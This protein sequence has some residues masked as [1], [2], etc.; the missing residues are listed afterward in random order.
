MMRRGSFPGS[1]LVALLLAAPVGA[2]EPPQSA[3]APINLFF[4]CAVGV[5]CDLDFL[6]REIPFVSWVRDRAD[7]DLHVLVT[8]EG[9]GGG[10]RLFTLV[11]I[12]L[13][14]PTGQEQRLT[15]S[16]SGDATV[17][18]QRNGVAGRLRLGLVRY[19]QN[20]AVAD[21]LVVSYEADDVPEAAGE[22]APGASR[23]DDPWDYWVF[24]VNLSG[25]ASGQA[26]STFSNWSGRLSAN[27]T[28]E[29]WK[30]DLGGNFFRRVQEFDFT[31]NG[32][33]QTIREVREDW[34]I[35]TGLVRSLGTRWAVGLSA[36]ANSST[37]LNQDLSVRVKPGVE[38]NFF[39]Y[40]ES[41]RRSLT[42]QYLIGPNHFEY[43]ERT[44]F[45]RT[46]ETLLQESLT[47]RLSLVQPWGR[48]STSVTAAHYLH[49]TQR[50]NLTVFGNANIR[51]F[52]G[53]SVFV[54]ANYQWIR[55]QLYISAEGA[56]TEQ[57]LLQQRQ[58]E[59]SYRYFYNVGIEY[60]FGSIF[61]NV[62][63]PRFGGGG[64]EVIFF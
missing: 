60:R 55:D 45:G 19:V 53:F 29:A 43:A 21:R 14:E 12:G 49:D 27:R 6:R 13:R 1:S 31:T 25:N 48:W 44:I 24:R 5:V 20:S 40:S 62:V 23:Q 41:S 64:G 10:G 36:D 16:S 2:Q 7:A 51:L 39:P 57:V 33:S 38:F 58:L 17:D 32:A 61:N 18:E 22:A 35:N 42:L 56:T 54:S 59:T 4:D 28:T 34:G 47:G 37:L 63:N 52:R 8:S 26:T 50:S 30:I 15:Y 11:F 9:T 3:E 46:D